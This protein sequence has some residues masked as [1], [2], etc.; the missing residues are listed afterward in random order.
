MTPAPRLS[1]RMTGFTLVEPMVIVGIVSALVALLLP[2]LGRAR[3]GAR[4]TA[5]AS[6]L[7]QLV[8]AFGMYYTDNRQQFP[9]AGWGGPVP[10]DWIH[11]QRDRDLR[12]SAVARYLNDAGPD[13]FRCPSDDIDSHCRALGSVGGVPDTYRYSYIFN[14]WFA[15]RNLLSYG[16]GGGKYVRRSSEKL[17]LIEADEATVI[18]GRWEAG[19]QY[20]QNEGRQDLLGIRHDPSRWR[21]SFAGGYPPYGPGRPDRT[22]RGNGAFLDGHVDYVTREYTWDWRNCTPWA[23]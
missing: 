16:G 22:S 1:T 18:S 17:L 10:H 23:P 7:R 12:E 6:N 2:A 20:M 5:C 15:E 11:W 8:T 9:A 21:G 3:E 19:M 14:H 13:V 4:R